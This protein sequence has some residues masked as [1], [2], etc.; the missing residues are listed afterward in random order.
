MRTVRELSHRV[1]VDKRE[2]KLLRAMA[3]EVMHF[4]VRKGV[5]T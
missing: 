4:L 1:P 3:L 5:A 2:V